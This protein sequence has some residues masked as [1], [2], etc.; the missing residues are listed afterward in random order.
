MVDELARQL[1]QFPFSKLHP[2]DFRLRIA[3][4]KPVDL[5]KEHVTVFVEIDDISRILKIA[6]SLRI[7]RCY[8]HLTPPLVLIE[9]YA[10]E[11]GSLI[12]D[13]GVSVVCEDSLTRADGCVVSTTD[14]CARTLAARS[15]GGTG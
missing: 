9:T 3:T 12:D 7:L 6:K 11:L 8:S 10:S 2:L 1:A 13:A 4:M 14:P 5:E 15:H